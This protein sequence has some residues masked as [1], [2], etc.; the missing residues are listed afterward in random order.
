M[1]RPRQEHGSILAL[2]M[3]IVL[4]LGVAGGSMLSGNIFR[5]NQGVR[6]YD[7]SNTLHLAEAGLAQAALHLK[8]ELSGD[9]VM[10]AALG[11]GSYTIESQA[12]IGNNLFQVVVRGE[13]GAGQR[14][15]ENI[16]RFVGLPVFQYAVLGDTAVSLAGDIETD[17]YDSRLGLYDPDPLSGTYN[18][19][20]EGDVAT[21][22]TSDGALTLAG[23]SLLIDGQLLT[24]PGVADPDD[25]VNGYLQ[26]LVTGGTDP[27]S[28]TQDV[29]SLPAEIPM[30]PVTV[31]SGIPCPDL[32]IGAGR[33]LDPPLSPTGGPLGNGTYCFHDLS[34]GGHATLPVTG[35]VTVYITGQMEVVGGTT[36]GNPSDPTDLMVYVTSDATATIT[37]G[38]FD[39]ESVFY[40][41]LYAP[42]AVI[43]IG[44][45]AQIFGAIAADTISIAG[46]AR[47][48]YDEALASVNRGPRTGTTQRIAWRELP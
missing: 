9:D 16:I 18:Q 15:L 41:A 37:A 2:T 6:T 3:G 4:I 17:S 19:S 27:P 7:R 10:S 35:P 30:V 34:V 47:I 39:G 43:A 48:H 31:P 33:V 29:V 12:P 28:N 38:A 5:V 40:G 1:T 14:R 44:G 26:G 25:L 22:N 11:T 32:T 20:H 21:N 13:N 36:V 42:D 45:E 24:G 46:D 8:T 23:S